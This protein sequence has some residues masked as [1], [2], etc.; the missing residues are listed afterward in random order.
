MSSQPPEETATKKPPQVSPVRLVA[1]PAQPPH[2]AADQRRIT[3]EERLQTLKQGYQ[4]ELRRKPT[5]IQKQLMDRA[6]LLSV[7]A[8]IA[9]YD[10]TTSA[11]DIVRLDRQAQRAREEMRRSFE[12]PNPTSADAPTLS[13]VLR[14]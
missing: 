13:Q 3:A 11:N 6:A 1:P 14:S 12:R 4:R 5:A 9:V 7:K 8:E 10:T 2:P